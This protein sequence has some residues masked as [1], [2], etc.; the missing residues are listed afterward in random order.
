MGGRCGVGP[1]V[2]QFLLITGGWSL[3]VGCCVGRLFC[4]ESCV[5]VTAH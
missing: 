3:Q 5:S 1:Y 2:G 4:R